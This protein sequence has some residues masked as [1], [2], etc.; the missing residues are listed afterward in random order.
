MKRYFLKLL[1]LVGLAVTMPLSQAQLKVDISGIGANQIPISIANFADESVAGQAISAIIRAD[2]QR[3]GM[4]KLI[5]T[6]ETLSE[7]A[8]VNLNSWKAKGA[9]AL[10]TGS[11]IKHSDE[12]IELRYKLSDTVRTVDLAAHN[13]S[14]QPQFIRMAAHKI[15][16]DI[17]EKLTGIRGAFATRITY[18]SR[19]AGEYKLEVADSDGENFFTALRSTE[20][21][22]SPTWS[23]DGTKLAYV[24]FESKKPVIYVQDLAN[25]RRIVAA[26]FKG[27]NSAPAWSPDGKKLAIALSR[28]GLTQ[29]Y[30]INEDGSDVKKLTR[31]NGID[32]EPCFSPDGQSIY[33]TSDRS[34]GPQIYRMNLDGADLRRLTYGGNYNI[35][36]SVSPDGKMLAYISRREGK[37]QLHILDMTTSQEQ[38]LSDTSHDESPSFAPNSRYILYATEAAGRGALTVVSIDGSAKYTLSARA[39]SVREPSWGPFSK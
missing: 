34:G 21:I 36:P 38:R 24:S 18:V 29:I 7:T 25:R 12:R 20:P 35:S 16:D 13:I 17:F 27:S 4:F 6:S 9:D 39:S 3:S 23:P 28:E 33:F 1:A 32:T 22:I 5:D 15:A 11:A 2:L 26:N 31:S 8:P 14:T 19:S 10:V 30:L 37:F